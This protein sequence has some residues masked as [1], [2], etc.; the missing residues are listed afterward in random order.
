MSKRERKNGGI[1]KPQDP[2]SAF[3]ASKVRL[4]PPRGIESSVPM[5]DGMK[6]F[7]ADL[8]RWA[9]RRG[10]AA[11]FAGTGLGKTLMQ[12]AWANAVAR[13]ADGK[14]LI[15]TP[16]AVAQQTVAEAKKFGIDGVA[17]ALDRE[18]QSSRI[19]ITNYDRFEKFDPADFVGIVLDESSIIKSHSSKTRAILIKS[20]VGI[21]YR[22][23][24]TATPAPNDWVELGNHSEFLGAMTEKEMLAMFFVHDGSVRAGE[25]DSGDG[26]RLK[27]HAEDAFWRWVSSWGAMVRHPRDLGYDDPGYDLPPLVRHQVTV[28]VEYKP[29]D[30]MLFPI[31]ARTMSERLSARRESVEDRVVAAA[32]IVNAE[33][34]R[35]WLVWCNLNTESEALAKAIPRALEVK[36]SDDRDQKA[37]RLLGFIDGKPPVL[38]SKPSIAGFGMNFQHCADMVFVGLNDSFE[39]LY[40]AI[41]R[42]WRFGQT[43]PV[44]VYLVASEL[45]GAVVANLEKKEAQYEAMGEAMAVHMR[46]LVRAEVRGNAKTI[47][48]VQPKVRM[49]V[50][51]WL[52]SSS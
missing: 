42:C 18:S 41:R 8:T 22:L 33:P 37:E 1:P 40:Q 47:D 27:R 29:T 16:L 13:D 15:L 24:C 17:Y 43:S 50:P 14:I 23:C 7:Q 3:L 34:D 39:Q 21:P 45:E 52:T 38:V 2:Y 11:I 20:C 5:P 31:E 36:G 51:Q 30:G 4:A 32:K 6:P 44:N 10:R 28:P 12:L 35:P 19:V 49:E 25:A 9:L 26:W 48:K 46:D